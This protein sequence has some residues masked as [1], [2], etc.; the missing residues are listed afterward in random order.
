M[1]GR[2]TSSIH[3]CRSNQP[4]RRE[5]APVREFRANPEQHRTPLRP[6]CESALRRPPRSAQPR[7]GGRFHRRHRRFHRACAATP[8]TTRAGRCMHAFR[9]DWSRRLRSRAAGG[10]SRTRCCHCPLTRTGAYR[11]RRADAG[12]PRLC[13]LDH[14]ECVCCRAVVTGHRARRRPEHEFRCDARRGNSC[15]LRL[16]ISNGQVPTAISLR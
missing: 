8:A 2:V 4:A 15:Q 5:L 6:H 10:D 3:M 12:R 11:A 13:R 14:P 9:W 7:G 16:Y 1:T